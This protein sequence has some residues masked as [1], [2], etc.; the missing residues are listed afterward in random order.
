MMAIAKL[1]ILR[2]PQ[3]PRAVESSQL[4]TR[5]FAEEATAFLQPQKY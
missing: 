1:Q 5:S 3:L 4:G 2:Q